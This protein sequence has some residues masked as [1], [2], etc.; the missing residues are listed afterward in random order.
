MEKYHA[1]VI[2]FCSRARFLDFRSVT[3]TLKF[4]TTSYGNTIFIQFAEIFRES[5]SHKYCGVVCA[6]GAE[7]SSHKCCEGIVRENFTPLV[8]LRLRVALADF[9]ATKAGCI[10][11]DAVETQRWLSSAGRRGI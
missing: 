11:S 7:Q 1:A 8:I 4:A 2:T 9:V 5:T 3:I 6:N 10:L